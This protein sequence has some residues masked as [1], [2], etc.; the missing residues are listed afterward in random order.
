MANSLAA[1]DYDQAAL[2]AAHRTRQAPRVMPT[3]RELWDMFRQ[4]EYYNGGYPR[5]GDLEWFLQRQYF[6]NA[7][8]RREALRKLQDRIRRTKKQVE[9]LMVQQDIEISRMREEEELREHYER[10]RDFYDTGENPD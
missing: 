10:H 5:S 6:P 1:G 7:F 9:K 2:D 3:H 8:H 4:S